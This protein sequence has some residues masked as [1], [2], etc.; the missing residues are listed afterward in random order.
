MEFKWK[1]ALNKLFSFCKH[2]EKE[3]GSIDTPLF[4]LEGQEFDAKVVKI[5]DGDTIHVVFPFKGEVTRWKIRMEGYDSPEIKSKN[6][7]EKIA[8]NVAK[9]ALINK[10][11]NNRVKLVCGKFDK[12]GRLLG[13]IFLGN[14]NVNTWMISEGYGYPYDGGTKMI[15]EPPSVM[16]DN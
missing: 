16:I 6:P 7:E 1:D 12:Y 2:K 5:Y 13:T 11:G 4:T 3:E 14:D 15:F 10:I 9:E 8:A